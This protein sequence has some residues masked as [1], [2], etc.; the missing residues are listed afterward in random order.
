MVGGFF[1]NF[2]RALSIIPFLVIFGKFAT[3]LL[4]KIMDI[5]KNRIPLRSC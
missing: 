5:Y 1:K 2:L 3:I 4:I